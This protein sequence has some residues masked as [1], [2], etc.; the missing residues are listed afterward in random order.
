MKVR[1]KPIVVDAHRVS[2]VEND[3]AALLYDF[4]R[5][6]HPDGPDAGQ[7]QLD[8]DDIIYHTDLANNGK[9]SIYTIEGLMWCSPGDYIIRGVRGELYACQKDIFEETYDVIEP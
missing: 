7:A 1:K 4:V 8:N 5:Q 6:S 2:P 3:G 9:V